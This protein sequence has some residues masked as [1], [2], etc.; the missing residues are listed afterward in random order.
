MKT[1]FPLLTL[2]LS[3]NIIIAQTTTIPDANFEQKLISLGYDSGVPDGLVLTSNINTITSLN[4]NYSS[5]TDLTGIE[6]FTSLLTLNCSGNQLTNFDI[7]QNSSLQYLDCSSS[8]LTSLN[9]IQNNALQ[10]LKCSYNQLTSLD[11]SQNTALTNLNCFD[12]QLTSLDLTQNTNL[13]G[14]RCNNNLLNS[15]NLT[16]NNVLYLLDCYGNQLSTLDVTQNTDLGSLDCSNNQLTSLDITQNSALTWLW[17]HNNQL[18]SIDLTQNPSLDWGIVS[19]NLLTSLN[20]TQNTDL[21]SL[22]CSNNQLNSLNLTQNNILNNLFCDSN[23]L[24]CLNI[25]N[26]NNQNIY[27]GFFTALGNPNLTCI[28]VDDEASSATYLTNIDPQTSFSTSC[29]NNCSFPCS[30][31]SNYS[32][33]NNGNGNYS[34]TN[35]STGNFNQS[36]WAFGDGTTSTSTNPNHTFTANGTFVVVLSINDSTSGPSCFDYFIDTIEVTAIASPLQCTSGFVM[37]SDT[38]TGDITVVNSS[39]GNNLTYLWDFGDGDTSTLQFPNHTYATVG[40]FYLCLTVDDGAGCTDMYCDSI[41]ENGVIFKQTGF[42]INVIAPL[43]IT[44]LDNNLDSSHEVQIY[45]NPVSNQLSIET[46]LE[47]NRIIII[48]VASK[49]IMTAKQNTKAVNVADLSDGVYFIQLIT[50]QGTVTKK[51]VKQ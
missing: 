25:K 5:I 1:L 24:N 15:I 3:F 34:F 45:P 33:M 2:L 11:V 6:D 10:T 36:H 22:N 23:E 30:V 18:T 43:V 16:Q 47:I 44:G 42:S 40:P 49:V 12:N 14:L 29:N 46:K 13:L 37:Y 28:E 19:G 26:G 4:V 51:F 21:T 48:D 41:G 7:T 31:S 9:V 32:I 27:G 38:S 35:T 39:T 8:Q 20:V 17:C 50:N